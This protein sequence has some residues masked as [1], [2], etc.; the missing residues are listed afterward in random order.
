MVDGSPNTPFWERARSVRAEIHASQTPEGACQVLA[1]IASA[2]AEERTPAGILQMFAGE[3]SQYRL[4]VSNL[5][6]VRLRARY[7][8]VEVK[9]LILGVATGAPSVQTITAGT[10]HGS[11]GLTLISREPVPGILQE[12]QSVLL[13]A[14]RTA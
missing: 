3:Q 1:R 11:L 14:C 9:T 6:E 8:N 2:V 5:G 10:L 4:L 12:A 7:G 13:N